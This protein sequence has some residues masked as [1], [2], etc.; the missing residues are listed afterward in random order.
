M[1]WGFSVKAIN[2]GRVGWHRDDSG[3]L[4]SKLQGIIKLKL[5][6]LTSQ[7]KNFIMRS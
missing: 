1:S 4:F 3:S 2:H 7:I 5:D 6:D